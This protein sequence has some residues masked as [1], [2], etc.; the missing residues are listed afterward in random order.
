MSKAKILVVEDE[1]ITALELVSTLRALGYDCPP[2]RVS[3]EEALRA[4]EG[5]RPDLVLMDIRLP[6]AM[7]GIEA[8]R[9]IRQRSGAA[10]VFMSALADEQ[11]LERARSGGPFG[12]L[13]KPFRDQELRATLETALDKAAQEA[14]LKT[15]ERHAR[16]LLDAVPDFAVLLDGQARILALNQG[17]A[18]MAGRTARDLVGR[19]AS[20]LWPEE[21]ASLRLGRLG[22]IMR[23][24][25]PAVFTTE[26]P[27]RKVIHRLEP[28]PGPAG[29]IEDWAVFAREVSGDRL[30]G[31]EDLEETEAWYRTLFEHAANAIV[32]VDAETG[33]WVDCNRR[34]HQDLGYTREEFLSLKGTDLEPERT[35]SEL[36]A[37]LD[38]V[39]RRGDA[40]LEA[41]PRAKKRRTAGHG[42]RG[43]D[44]DRER[45]PLRHVHGPRPDR[46]KKGRPDPG[47]ERKGAVPPGQAARRVQD[48]PPGPAPE[49]GR[50]KAGRPGLPPRHGQ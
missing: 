46:A 38:D 39:R 47:P 42:R 35:P 12:Y 45:P 7:D 17:L 32:L 30:R 11:V 44:R 33:A 16:L 9:L 1:Y 6:G 34:A 24:G 10:V 41:R 49:P 26:L 43:T 8:A 15:R 36:Q 21:T 50:R 22:R 2:P 4:A 40:A 3:G 25:R 29:R 14:R 48:R 19:H 31:D 5:E 37:R 13:V 23:A 20:A 28:I 27:D 18:D